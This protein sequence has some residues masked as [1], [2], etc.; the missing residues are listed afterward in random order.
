MIRLYLRLF[1]ES[2]HTI[3]IKSKEGPAH[4]ESS[5]CKRNRV[6]HESGWFGSEG[7]VTYYLIYRC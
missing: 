3:Q 4:L 1:A 7:Y 6:S 5:M 2:T